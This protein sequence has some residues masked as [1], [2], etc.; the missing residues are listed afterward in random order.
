MASKIH[1]RHVMSIFEFVDNDSSFRNRIYFA[2]I[3][4]PFKHDRVYIKE[5]FW[6]SSWE[7]R[8]TAQ[9]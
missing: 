7:L 4:G 2:I 6:D 3:W 1:C 9:P 5:R 8:H